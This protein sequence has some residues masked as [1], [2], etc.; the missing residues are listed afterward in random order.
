MNDLPGAL[1]WP[2]ESPTFVLLPTNP[3][4]AARGAAVLKFFDWALTNG[5]PAARGLQY[6][7]LPEKV[8][9]EVRAAWKTAGVTN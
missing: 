5:D 8:K 6:I 7:P 4:D 9:T 3:K 1:S 2:I